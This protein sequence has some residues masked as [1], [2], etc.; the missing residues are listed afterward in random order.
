MKDYKPTRYIFDGDVA[1]ARTIVGDG[2][3]L[4]FQLK[5]IQQAGAPDIKH[6]ENKYSDGV[7][8]MADTSI[9]GID[10]VKIFVPIESKSYRDETE[11]PIPII[12]IF[13]LSQ[14]PS[15]R[16]HIS[17]YTGIGGYITHNFISS[18]IKYRDIDA[19]NKIKY[20]NSQYDIS[21]IERVGSYDLI[22][23]YNNVP[24][25][26]YNIYDLNFNPPYLYAT[27]TIEELPAYDL[28][29]KY[30]GYSKVE[31]YSDGTTVDLSIAGDGEP[32]RTNSTYSLKT[33]LIGDKRMGIYGIVNEI[34]ANCSASGNQVDSSTETH[35][36]VSMMWQDWDFQ[37]SSAN[38]EVMRYIYIYATSPEYNSSFNGDTGSGYSIVSG[39]PPLNDTFI[40]SAWTCEICVRTDEDLFII[41]SWNYDDDINY[42][43]YYVTQIDLFDYRGS[44]VYMYAMYYT[45]EPSVEGNDSDY[46]VE[47]GFIY[48]RKLHRLFFTA[49]HYDSTAGIYCHYFKD[50]TY[51]S[52]DGKI[53]NISSFPKELSDKAGWG[54]FRAGKCKVNL[55]PNV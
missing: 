54:F 6:I 27:V 22:N 42:V 21:E 8:V 45:T 1:K 7:I 23:T 50:A 16:P 14:I 36:S 29:G 10:L 44:P 52:P 55:T 49:D 26:P 17:D 40:P 11:F 39:C 19:D 9:Y 30:M 15:W 38:K 47:Y 41:K 4:L 37:G 25:W 12:E 35:M 28:D 34:L 51:I 20:K 53:K 31:Y 24:G 5:N 13:S 18:P 32:Y 33:S 46:S 43:D 3:R 48:M 2:N